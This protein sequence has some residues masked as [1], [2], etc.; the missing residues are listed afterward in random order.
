MPSL[1]FRC[2]NSGSL[3]LAF[4]IPACRLSR[5]LFLNRSP[6][7]SSANAARGGLASPSAGRR[8]R[9]TKPSSTTQHCFTKADLHSNLP[10]A[11][12]AH[13]EEHV[14]QAHL[15]GPRRGRGRGSDRDIVSA[16]FRCVQE[17]EDPL[18]GGQ[19]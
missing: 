15:P 2:F 6:Q 9:A 1:V 14:L 13:A 16:L 8:R 18:C 19:T 12:V 4:L 5:R 10:V 17:L 11:F 7:R 3:T